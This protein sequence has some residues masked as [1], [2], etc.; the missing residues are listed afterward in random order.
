MKLNKKEERFTIVA[1]RYD[2][3]RSVL[4]ENS[5]DI[6]RIS[7]LVSKAL[8]ELQADVISIRRVYE[9]RPIPKQKTL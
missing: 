3:K 5:H 2:Q 6:H 9:E 4:Y 8:H 7:V 1:F